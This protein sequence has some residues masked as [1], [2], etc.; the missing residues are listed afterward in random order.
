MARNSLLGIIIVVIALSH[1]PNTY[2]AS[3]NESRPTVIG[4]ETIYF[5]RNVTPASDIQPQNEDEPAISIN[6]VPSSNHGSH[7][8]VGDHERHADEGD[9]SRHGAHGE[10]H[11]GG[12]HLASWRW[13]EYSSLVVFILVIITAAV[14]KLLFHHCHCLASY[15]PE[16]CVLIIIGIV[17][18]AWATESNNQINRSDNAVKYPVLYD[19]SRKQKLSFVDD[20]YLSGFIRLSLA[21]QYLIKL[22]PLKLNGFY[23]LLMCV[24][25]H[26]FEVRQSSNVV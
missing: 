25:R 23:D 17:F 26:S 5:P 6:I 20:E 1:D 3:A 4:D 24:S 19:T 12:I 14:L 9:H 7:A 11:H 15:F 10:E 21:N 18:G 2:S 22:Y 16:S 8:E 13:E